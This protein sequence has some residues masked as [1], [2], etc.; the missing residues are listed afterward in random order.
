[1]LG[2]APVHNRVV[3]VVSADDLLL[4]PVVVLVLDKAVLAVSTRRLARR[5]AGGWHCEGVGACARAS[6]VSRAR[7]ISFGRVETSAVDG[8]QLQKKD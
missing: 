5:P 2:Q 1:M 4:Q 3:I 8:G 7:W 6:V